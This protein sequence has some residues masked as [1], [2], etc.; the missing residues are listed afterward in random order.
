MSRSYHHGER[1]NRAKRIRRQTV[2]RRLANSLLIELEYQ[3]ALAEAE[4]EAAHA[5]SKISKR[6]KSKPKDSA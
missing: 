1:K 2:S 5:K 4:A 6:T 3:Q